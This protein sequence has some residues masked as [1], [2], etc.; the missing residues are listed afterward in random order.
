MASDSETLIDTV[1]SIRIRAK[2]DIS[3]ASVNFEDKS[4]TASVVV[5]TTMP[6][7]NTAQLCSFDIDAIDVEI[8]NINN[9]LKVNVNKLRESPKDAELQR[10]VREA[11]QRLIQLHVW[12]SKL[13][14]DDG[15][16]FLEEQKLKEEKEKIEERKYEIDQV[17]KTTKAQSEIDICFLMDCTG[18]M[19]RH[20]NT[21]KE[22]IHILT[23]TIANLFKVQPRVAFIGYR[24]VNNRHSECLELDFTKNVNEFKQFLETVRA[25]GSSDYDFCEDVFSMY[26]LPLRRVYE[27]LLTNVGGQYFHYAKLQKLDSQH[28]FF[29]TF[30]LI[31]H[32]RVT[33]LYFYFKILFQQD[34]N[35]Y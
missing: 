11:K 9:E 26:I 18:S 7:D 14:T 12:T 31:D 24:D 4:T 21:A 15:R 2:S 23:S 5:N 28:F 17:L 6:N 34:K 30:L 33:L 13:N 19:K 16:R 27:I 1:D 35:F 8:Q 20:I 22:N 10:S 3:L 32:T 25:K 29:C